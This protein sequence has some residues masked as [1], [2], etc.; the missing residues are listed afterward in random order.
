MP[1]RGHSNDLFKIF[2]DLPRIRHRTP[3]DHLTQMRRHVSAT[4]DRA[5]GNIARQREATSRVLAVLSARRR[6]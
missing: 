6:R 2:P 5:L 3:E 1:R 4:R